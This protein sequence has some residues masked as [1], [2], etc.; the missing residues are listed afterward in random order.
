[1]FARLRLCSVFSVATTAHCVLAEE[2]KIQRR[3]LYDDFIADVA[4][5]GSP[6]LVCITCRARMGM[7]SGSGFIVESSGKI[8]TNAHVV[9]SCRGGVNVTLASGEVLSATVRGLDAASDLALLYA[10]SDKALPI[11]ELGNS[12][13]VR[14]GEFVVALGSP[15]TLKNTVTHG[16]ISAVNREAYELN[17]PGQNNVYLQTDATIDV[18]NSGGPLLNTSAEVVGINSMRAAAS[19]GIGF[20]VPVN[21][22]KEVIRQLDENGYVRRPFIGMRMSTLTPERLAS[23]KHTGSFGEL[24]YGILVHSVTRGSPADRAGLEPG[25]IVVSLDGSPVKSVRQFSDTIGYEIGRK[26]V[27]EVV[28]S[29]ERHPLKFV[30]VTAPMH[31]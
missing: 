3:V 15:L 5:R 16:I 9:Q 12:D 11:V 4:E 27:L 18:G 26:C 13:R 1:M 23:L 17:I 10:K 2:P 25:D 24:E 30:I 14:P 20:A 21:L 19:T 6:A 31:K 22:A 28:R 7:S 8:I 29:T